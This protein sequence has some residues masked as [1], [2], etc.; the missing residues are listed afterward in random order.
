MTANV[1]P[2]SLHNEVLLLSLPVV[3]DISGYFSWHPAIMAYPTSKDTAQGI[4]QHSLAPKKK[5]R[6]ITP[7]HNI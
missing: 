3:S 4:T 2:N 1:L 7:N 6:W 5:N